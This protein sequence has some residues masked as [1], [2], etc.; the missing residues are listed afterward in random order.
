MKTM[1]I[2]ITGAAGR[3]AYS[4]YNIL[5]SGKVLGENVELELNL[6][7]VPEKNKEL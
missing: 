4:M 2:L 6:L 1:K 7:D 5:C 3:I